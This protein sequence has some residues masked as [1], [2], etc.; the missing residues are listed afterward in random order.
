M[1]NFDLFL[2][3]DYSGAQTPTARLSGLQVYAVRPGSMEPER[4]NAPARVNTGQRVNWTRRQVA[5]RLRD[6][7]RSGRRLLAGIDH[8][9]SF[10]AS[11]FARYGLQCWS[12]F[13]D[14]FVTHWPTLGDEVTVDHVRD[15]SLHRSGAAPPPGSRVGATDELRLTERWTPSAKSV[16]LFDVQGAVAKSTHAGIPWLKWLRDEL[17]DA[18]HVWP[19]DG[20]A[21][22]AGK[23]VIVEVYPS[24]FR[25]RY[26]RAERSGDEQDAWSTARWMA[27]MAARGA[28]GDYFAPP[29][30]ESERAVA[31]LEGWIF[32][33]R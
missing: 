8:G 18:A 6:E 9:F 3:I 15:G 10:P 28:L 17:G 25:R 11:Y 19:F 5:E 16:F 24:L 32:G 21:P 26:P 14:D 20:W 13:L 33:V 1:I 23:A 2:G 7:V 27:E 29:L 30:L 31:A 22:P 4:W 12:E